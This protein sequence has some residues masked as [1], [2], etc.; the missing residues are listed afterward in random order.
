MNA[1]RD[2]DR[3]IHAFLLEGE[4]QL[5]DQVYDVVRAE[6]EQTQQRAFLGPWRMPIM[7]RI[8]GFGL[9][10]AAAVLALLVGAQFLGSS[11]A[12]VGG[13]G[14][15]ATASPPPEPT[16]TSEPSA[17]EPTRTPRVGLP[18][19]PLVISDEE[20]RVTVDIGSPGW[21][22]LSGREAISKDDDGLDAPETVGVA[23]IAW[24]WPAETEFN[25]Y[26]D[27]CQWTTTIPETPATTPD[28]IA[29]GF[30]AQSQTDAT[31]PVDV[32]VG[33][34]AGKAVTVQTPMSYEVPNA[35]R[36]E[37]FGDC[38]GDAFA[39]YG[40]EGDDTSHERNSQGPGEIDELWIL[41]VDGV[42]VILDAVY[43][44]AAPA[45]LVE[46]LRTLAES[47]T[48]EAP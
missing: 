15:D 35:T 13:P 25:V 2:P 3:L 6:I 24:A 43:G 17:A 41:D 32:T 29:A 4:E 5:H 7:N 1:R 16:P 45:G 19:G 48:F 39:F 33:G 20:V 11:G 31:E 36:E 37:E 22:S 42:I 9:A 34:Y 21:T 47:A 26:G 27:P 18:E 12:N 23:L 14:G 46:E 38:D 8:V 28:E 10:A 30:A 44:P 40:V